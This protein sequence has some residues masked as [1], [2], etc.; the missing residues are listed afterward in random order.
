MT[1]L[2]SS[3]AEEVLEIY[4]ES[5]EV[6]HMFAEDCYLQWDNL[7]S[8]LSDRVKAVK[9]GPVAEELIVLE[10]ETEADPE[11]LESSLVELQWKVS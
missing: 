5:K 8:S 3:Q 11:E 6:F 9:R 2:F 4:T 1:P 10:Q 7:L